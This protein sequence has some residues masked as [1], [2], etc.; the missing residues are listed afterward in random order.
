[1]NESKKME[2]MGGILLA[3][4]ATIL[5]IVDL[6]AGKFGDDEIIAINEKASAFAWY[7]SK[8]IKET[9][10]EGEKEL[11]KTLVMSG[12]IEKHNV[13]MLNEFEEKLGKKLIKY[14]KEKDEILR[15]SSLV[16]K[17]NWM[18]EK[19]GKLGQIIGAEEWGKKAEILG[20]S[21]DL[22]DLSVLFFHISLVLGAVSLVIEQIKLKKVF[23]VIMLVLGGLGIYFGFSAYQIAITA[24]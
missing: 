15:G 16:G 4:L 8:S 10:V 20:K 1:M 3:L 18:Q 24:A 5:S 7:Q 13:Q 9:S 22:F 14:Q 11:L 21:G 12:I 6:A 17:A 2:L 23:M 19:E